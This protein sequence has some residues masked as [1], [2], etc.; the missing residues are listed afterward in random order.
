[1]PPGRSCPPA[2]SPETAPCKAR[3]ATTRRGPAGTGPD[4]QTWAPT[5]AWLTR[6]PSVTRCGPHV[7]DRRQDKREDHPGLTDL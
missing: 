5:P 1:M 4:G 7:T 6:P 2:Q 3:A